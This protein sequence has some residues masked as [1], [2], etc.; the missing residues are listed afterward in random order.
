M[1]QDPIADRTAAVSAISAGLVWFV[2]AALSFSAPELLEAKPEVTGPRLAKLGPLL[3]AGW[4]ILLIPAALSL[5][6][7]LSPRAP[8]LVM[9]FT[10]YGVLSL[11]FWAFGGV[12]QITPELEITYLALA[13]IWWLGT[14]TM[15][16]RDARWLGVCTIVVGAFAAL[17]ALLSLFE[18]VP[19]E[20]YVLAA[21]KLPLCALWSI[22]MGF[23]LWRW[24]TSTR[25]DA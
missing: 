10:V 20:I 19:F 13:A 15:L 24:P 12:T 21:P 22:L 17:D 23:A 9:M 6:R 18:P 8:G 25:V 11:A 16:C 1:N 5:H 14:G 4:N 3:T 2:W 7:K